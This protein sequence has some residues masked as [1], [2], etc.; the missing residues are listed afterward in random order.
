MIVTTVNITSPTVYTVVPETVTI[1]IANP[2]VENILSYVL[3]TPTLAAGWVVTGLVFGP[4]S[5]KQAGPATPCAG[6]YCFVD[7]SAKAAVFSV[8]INVTNTKTGVSFSIDP[9]VKNIH[10]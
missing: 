3:D 9:Q 7:A 4:T 6:G 5:N 1:L 10:P 2:P 8:T